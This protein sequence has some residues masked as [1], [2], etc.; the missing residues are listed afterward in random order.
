MFR[1]LCGGAVVG[2]VLALSPTGRADEAA[3]K[4]Q[5]EKGLKAIGGNENL[6]KVKAA[7]HRMKG[8]FHGMGM[9]LPYT[10][11]WIMQFPDQMRFTIDS[12][13]NGMKFTLTRVYNRG[14]GW[15]KTMDVVAE[16]KPEEIEESKHDLYAMWVMMLR[17]LLKEPGFTLTQ[18]GEVQVEKRPTVGVKVAR[19]GQR[20]IKLYFDKDSALL[21]KSEAVVRDEET[22]KEVN[23]EEFFSDYK[24]IDGI[25]HPMKALIKRDGKVYVE[26]ETIEVKIEDKIDEARFGKP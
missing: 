12:E 7:T 20:D 18:L 5:I 8:T 19:K 21:V 17:P 3:A 16:L 1:V 13:V 15:S 14:K 4:A 9:A 2:L 23:Q 10:G 22:G 26:G 24:E 25:K 6:A 11:E